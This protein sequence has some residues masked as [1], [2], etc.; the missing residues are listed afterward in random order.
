[1]R[2]RA[3]APRPRRFTLGTLIALAC[4][5][6]LVACQGAEKPRPTE[7]VSGGPVM[8]VIERHSADLLNVPGVVG[9]Y[10][11][12]TQDQR[13]VIRIMVAKRTPEH[14]QKLPKVLEGYPVEIEETGEIRPLQGQ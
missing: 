11:G 13:P 3:F 4:A 8:D 6:V 5:L 10:E 7:N 9:V 1:M 14:D 2:H 12:R